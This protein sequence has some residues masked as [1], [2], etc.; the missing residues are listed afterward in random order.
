MKVRLLEGFSSEE[1]FAD[2][3]GLT[4]FDGQS[5]YGEVP[6]Y[7]DGSFAAK[8]PANVPLHMQLID[9]FAMSVATEDIWISGRPGEQRFCGGCHE[10]RAKNTVIA[11]GSTEAVQRGAINLDVPA[12]RAHV[13]GLQLREGPRRA[14]EPGHPADLRRQVRR[15]ATTAT[16]PSPAT[17]ATPSSTAPW[18]PC[19]P[20]PSTCASSRCRSWSASGSDYDY[21]ASY[22]SLMGLEMELG[23]NQVEIQVAGGGQMPSYVTPGSALTV[24]ADQEAEPAPALPRGEPGRARLPGATHPADVGGQELTPDEYYRLILNIDMGAPVL[25]PREHACPRRCPE[26][27]NERWRPTP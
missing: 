18:A 3:F 11:P 12:G 22:V 14:L 5:R 4:E 17:A 1:G 15:A 25:L 8:V 26:S 23:E 19:R 24:A 27:R 2:M 21:P 13:D 7:A 20:S 9:K 6:V 10:D 16:P